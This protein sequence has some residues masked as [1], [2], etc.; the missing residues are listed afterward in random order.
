MV[1]MLLHQTFDMNGFLQLHKITLLNNLTCAPQ[2]ELAKALAR[3]EEL[4][5]HLA[6][7]SADLNRA[8]QAYTSLSSLWVLN[9]CLSLSA[10]TAL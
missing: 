5:A 3:S 9:H 8:V 7:Q 10:I 4:S 2:I 6:Q 1:S